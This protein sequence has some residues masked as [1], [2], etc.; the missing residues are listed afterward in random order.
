[1]RHRLPRKDQLLYRRCDEVLHYLWDPIGISSEPAARDEYLA[2]LPALF[3]LVHGKS[4][5]ASIQQFLL[6]IESERMGLR[7]DSARAMTIAE[8]LIASREWIWAQQE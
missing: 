3:R 1:M 4:D 2:Y 6:H 7:P 5:A 8:V